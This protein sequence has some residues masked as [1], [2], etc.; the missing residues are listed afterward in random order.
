[1]ARTARYLLVASLEAFSGKSATAIGIA[2]GLQ[3]RGVSIGY[4]KPLGHYLHQDQGGVSEEEDVRLLVSVL[5]LPPER[6]G[7]P[8]AYLSEK[9]SEQSWEQA[10]DLPDYKS[11]L[12][13]YVGGIAGD[14]VILEA[15]PTL[16][17]GRIFNLSA[18]QIAGAIEAKV[19]LVTPY[20]SPCLVDELLAAKEI[21]GDRLLGTVINDVPASERDKARSLMAP[22]LEKHGIAVLGLLPET[23]LLHSVSVRNLARELDA[24]VLCRSDRLDLMVERLT[25][26]AMNVNAALEY[27][28]RGRNLAVVT[29]SDRSDLQLAALETS[30]HCLILTGHVP[31]QDFILARAEMLEIP[32]LSVES[33]TLTTVEIAKKTFNSIRLQEPI[34]IECICDLIRQH[35]DLDRLLDALGLEPAYS[36]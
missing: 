2:S 7:M 11:A 19:L 4:G 14:V 8:L 25:I 27:F 22:F 16:A 26:G 23:A 18:T 1:M 15:A 30:A 13:D 9:T 20:D 32:V 35:F 17:Q 28:R 34:K 12:P 3:K 5:G 6:V 36:N 10:T 24:E 31:P 33:D 29:G 21:L